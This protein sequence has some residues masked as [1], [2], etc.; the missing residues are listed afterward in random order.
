MLAT[1]FGT[2]SETGYRWDH[3]TTLRKRPTSV[4]FF[5]VTA[6]HHPHELW[7]RTGPG[8][9]IK[10]VVGL[11]GYVYIDRETDRVTR[12]SAVAEDIPAGFP[13]QRSST[14]LDYDYADIGGTRYLLPL[15][16][17]VRIDAGKLQSLNAVEFQKYRKFRADASVSFDK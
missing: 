7:F 16:A 6:S 13:V 12:I 5:R 14:V 8:K 9:A 10:A 11:H 17:E 4:Y 15:R 2:A 3:W 1:V